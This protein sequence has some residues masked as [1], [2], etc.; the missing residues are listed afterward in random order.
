MPESLMEALR[1]SSLSL[2]V[3]FLALALFA[4]LI[5]ALRAT[6]SVRPGDSPPAKAPHPGTPEEELAAAIGLAI[7]LAA[8]GARS[9]PNLGQS[10]LD[11][12]GPYWVPPG[13]TSRE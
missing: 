13:V 12:A 10:L 8:A 2:V 3:T 11:G 7:H 6:F 4:L 1:L 5:L 9:D